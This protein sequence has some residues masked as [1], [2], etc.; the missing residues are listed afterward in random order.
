MRN[1]AGKPVKLV[2]PGM[3]VFTM[4]WKELPDPGEVI[5]QE[6]K[7]SLNMEDTSSNNQQTQSKADD[8]F[9]TVPLIVKGL[10]NNSYD[11]CHVMWCC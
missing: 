2:T 10:L 4:G 8:S 11:T 5:V 9:I 3:P 7:P 1:E 6:K